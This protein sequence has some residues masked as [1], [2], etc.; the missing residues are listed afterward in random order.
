MRN[1]KRILC[2]HGRLVWVTILMIALSGCSNAPKVDW[3]VEINGAVSKPLTLRY[4]DLAK[5]KQVELRDVLMRRSQGEDT[6]NTWVGPDL[7]SILEEAGVSANA[8]GITAL[9]ADG[10]AMQMTMDDLQGAIIALKQDGEWIADDE[11]Q[12]PIRLVCPEKPA[13]HW[14]FQLA[15]IKVEE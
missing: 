11:D 3:T 15:E 10:Y 12:G 8:T 7:A 6:V 5:R 13:N 14:L 1:V 4:A 9:A 2:D